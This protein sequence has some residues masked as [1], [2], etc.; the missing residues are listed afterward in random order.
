MAWHFSESNTQYVTMADDAA[1]D[2][3]DADWSLGGWIKSDGNVGSLWQYFL[4][5]A[6]VGANNS[7]NLYFGEDGSSL[8]N[9]LVG[10]FE[11][12]GGDGYVTPGQGAHVSDGTPGD[13]TLWQ[14]ILYV[15]SVT[16]QTLYVNAV[17]DEVVTNA[18]VDA[19]SPAGAMYFGAR[20]GDPPDADRCFG[21]SLASWAKWDRA[22]TAN[23]RAGLAAKN[24]PSAYS[25]GLAWHLPMLDYAEK[26]SGITVTNNGSTLVEGPPGLGL[27]HIG[28]LGLLGVGR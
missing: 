28:S 20:T 13:S 2:L 3:P 17:A 15:R 26:V 21:G 18:S 8:I 11:D 5:H 9:K 10:H 1:L 27:P 14:H 6:A 25:T 7:C 4:S 19:I 22:L 16:T 12:A 23:E 24:Q